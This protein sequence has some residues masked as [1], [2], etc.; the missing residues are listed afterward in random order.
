[1]NGRLPPGSLRLVGDA[2]AI[3]HASL[4]APFDHRAQEIQVELDPHALFDALAAGHAPS[5]GTP[6]RVTITP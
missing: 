4:R 2:L 5:I 6:T 3:E 1:M